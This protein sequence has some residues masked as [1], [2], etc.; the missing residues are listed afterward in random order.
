MSS[1]LFLLVVLSTAHT[2]QRAC[3]SEDA[4]LV[5][6]EV[7]VLGLADE[8]NVALRNQ[9]LDLDET[10]ALAYTAAEAD[11]LSAAGWS[12]LSVT[13]FERAH[14]WQALVAGTIAK[15]LDPRDTHAAMIWSNAVEL[16]KAGEI[17]AE[18]MED[19]RAR[20]RQFDEN[21][22]ISDLKKGIA[23]HIL[24][25]DSQEDRSESEGVFLRT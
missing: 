13:L 11:P 19:A 4:K 2:A 3:K 5:T 8:C 14:L 17:G 23:Q 18:E 10:V 15:R 7:D 21:T 24:L 25:P 6:P 22:P 20:L 9:G 12:R 1:V 16:A